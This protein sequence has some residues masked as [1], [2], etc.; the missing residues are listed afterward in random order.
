LGNP[1]YP[2][3]TSSNGPNWVD[4]LTVKYNVSVIETYNL[5]YGGATVD[6]SLAKPYLPTVLSLQQQVQQ[7]FLPLYTGQNA[8]ATWDPA[9]TL[10][11]FFFGINDV[12]NTYSANDPSN[13]TNVYA[14]ILEQYSIQVNDLFAAGAR[15]YLFLNVPPVQRSP[16]TMGQGP[17]ASAAESEAIMIFNNGLFDIAN[18]LQEVAANSNVPVNIDIFDAYSLFNSVLDN[19]KTSPQ[20]A[21]YI[22][23]TD[24]CLAYENGTA[25]L[26]SFDTSCVAPLDAYFWLNSL[27]PT[28]PMHDLL[29]SEIARQLGW[30]KP[31]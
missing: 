27:H 14:T 11:A 9:T 26:T 31:S 28:F 8:V 25:E 16:L 20:T 1:T 24:Y 21:G 17:N 12:G 7:E 15:N 30:L 22:N 29:A 10:F 18:S 5:A 3:P 23:T 2:G 13:Y 4:Y 6:S 19:P